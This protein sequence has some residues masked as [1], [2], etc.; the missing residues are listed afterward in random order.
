MKIELTD[1]AGPNDP[2]RVELPANCRYTGADDAQDFLKIYILEETL[3]RVDEYLASDINNEL[4]GVLTGDVGLT[5]RGD[6]FITIDNFIIAKHSS[7]SISRLTFT[8][9]TWNYINQILEKDLPGKKILGWFHSHP[10]HTVFLSSYDIFIHENFFNM[11]Y[12]VA[13]VF[14]PTIKDRGFFSWA[15]KKVVKSGGYY[16]CKVL[17]S[18]DDFLT[19]NPDPGIMDIER[20]QDIKSGTPKQD[21]KNFFIIGLLS[22]MLILLLFI[23]YNIYDFRQKALLKEEYEKDLLITK[24]ENSKLSDRLNEYIRESELKKTSETVSEDL[25]QRDLNAIPP[26][27][28]ENKNSAA[29]NNRNGKSNITGDKSV[30]TDVNSQNSVS[31]SP[32]KLTR[33]KVKIGDTLEKISMQF[34]KSNI[35]INMILKQNKIKN[36]SNIK[37]GQELDLP[38]IPQ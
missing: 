18:E 7:S 30:N 31:D 33:Y 32:L 34:Y 19:L 12:M 15:N 27:E 4:G 35:G 38:N 23:I 5:G 10:G 24:N 25:I 37:I 9:E 29:N 11:D 36:K 17:K 21:H 1:K 8:H 13:Y 20:R 22:L 6:S 26:D 14:D 16:V 28:Q 3:N 2:R